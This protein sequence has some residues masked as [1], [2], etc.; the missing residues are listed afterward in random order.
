VETPSVALHVGLVSPMPCH[1]RGQEKTW[2]TSRYHDYFLAL[3]EYRRPGHGVC[4]MGGRVFQ[5]Q[6][7]K[8]W[9]GGLALHN[10]MTDKD[11][12]AWRIIK[13]R[14]PFPP[15]P[16]KQGRSTVA[17]ARRVGGDWIGGLQGWLRSGGG[18][19]R[20]RATTAEEGNLGRYG[21]RER[22]RET[23]RGT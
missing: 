12:G 22:E 14:D 11:T 9:C 3:T 1:G 8:L 21:Q 13:R 15:I 16:S 6:R 19:D 5:I 2:T 4:V 17:R 23:P 10:S 20:H 7:E 18:Q